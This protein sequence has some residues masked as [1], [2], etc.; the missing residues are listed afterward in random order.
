MLDAIIDTGMREVIK[1]VIDT[2]VWLDWLLFQD[3]STA[4]LSRLASDGALQCLSS[5]TMRAELVNVIG[6]PYLA[7]ALLRIDPDHDQA[8]AR[9][10]AKFEAL[11]TP[12]AD[13]NPQPNAGPH[14]LVCTDPD[15]QV[16]LDLAVQLR[17]KYLLSRDRALLKLNR[18]AALQFDLH[19]VTPEQFTAVH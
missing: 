14:G 6:R 2:N 11:I 13:P 5:P 3:D 16:F 4:T 7:R 8:I 19:I 10:I 17:A 15:D 9:V 18:R 12:N 1:V